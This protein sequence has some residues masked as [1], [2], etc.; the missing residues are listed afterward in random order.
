MRRISAVV[1]LTMITVAVYGLDN[2][3]ALLPPM[4][5]STRN[6]GC[7]IT[8]NFV[9]EQIDQLVSSG[10]TTKGFNFIVIEDC[11]QVMEM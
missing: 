10:L 8:E 3:A 6:I 9:R 2:G 5:L 1:M 4:L 11:W 7:N